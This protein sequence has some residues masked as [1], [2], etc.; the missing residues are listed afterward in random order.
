[1]PEEAPGRGQEVRD[2]SDLYR[3]TC[4]HDNLVFDLD[5]VVVGDSEACH[6]DMSE[7]VGRKLRTVISK[8][9]SRL[10]RGA[11]VTGKYPVG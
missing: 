10:D 7:R 3:H 1:M 8:A 5:E 6:I 4:D 2:S 9:N 11:T